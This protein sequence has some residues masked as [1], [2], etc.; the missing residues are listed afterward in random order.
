MTARSERHDAKNVSGTKAVQAAG[1]LFRARFTAL[2][3]F[4][5]RSLRQSRKR[6][7]GAAIYTSQ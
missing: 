3:T 7:A 6:P 2:S 4:P 1:G 5:I